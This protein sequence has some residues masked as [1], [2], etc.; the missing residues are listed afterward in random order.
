MP[1]SQDSEGAS[2]DT[3]DECTCKVGRVLDKYS[4]EHLDQELVDLWTADPDERQSLRELAA[5]LNRAILRE[6]AHEAGLN[7]VEEMV[8]TWYRILTDEDQSSGSETQV[9]LQLERDGVD[10]DEVTGDFVSYQT[11]NR[12]LK[13]CRGAERAARD[14]TDEENIRRRVQS[15]YALENKIIA[16]ANDILEQLH[17]TGRISLSNFEIFVSITIRCSECGT[18][19]N[20]SDIVENKGC[21]CTDSE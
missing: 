21:H 14:E 15:I 13:Q 1:K 3:L 18:H 16:V 12:H 10:V 4:I 2:Y 8:D 17:N 6:A 9:R 20:I 19:H 5:Y 7:P 11:I